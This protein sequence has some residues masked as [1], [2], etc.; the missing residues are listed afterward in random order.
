MADVID[1]KKYGFKEIDSEEK[2]K[3][4]PPV[5]MPRYPKPARRLHLVTQTFGQSIEEAYFWLVSSIRDDWGL[6]KAIKI[7]DIFTA[8]E[9][10]SFWGAAQQRLQLQQSQ[11]QQ[12]LGL[13]GKLLKDLFQLVREIRI[14]QER[15][16]LYT[17]SNKQIYKDA[18]QKIIRPIGSRRK[19]VPEE[20]VLKGYW[21]DMKDGGVKAPGSVYGLASTL[22]Y[23]TLPD[24]FF[25]APS[26]RKEEVARY[27]DVGLKDFNPRVRDV[28][29]KKLA[30]YLYW[31]EYTFGELSTRRKF[32][33]KYLRQHYESIQLYISWV[34]PYLKN[35]KRLQQN[36]EKSTSE[37]LIGAFEG[38]FVEIETLFYRD[39]PGCSK[40]P[41]CLLTMEFRTQ[42]HM[43]FHQ[44]GYQHKGPVHVGR[45]EFWMRGYCWTEKQIEKY[46]EL[47]EKETYDL[48]G[49]V[50]E[51]L[52][53]ALESLGKDIRDYL[54]GQDEEFPEDVTKKKEDEEEA[55]EKKKAMT[56]VID[57]FKSIFVGFK[58]IF[59][60]FVPEKE[61]FKG[62]EVPQWKQD[63][64][65][66]TALKDLEK[67]MYPSY[68]NFKKAH[69]M[70]TW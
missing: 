4:A 24:L 53:D 37:D 3:Y 70:I 18:N 5:P 40:K 41:V 47:R 56:G 49:S 51:S 64:D 42:P 60:T 19:S 7:T 15:L 32:T 23:S 2:T 65:F 66:K 30:A 38:S 39:I 33:I 58:D 45:T 36:F 52:K 26:M 6:G 59:R 48:L 67:R 69:R 20:T 34:K 54:K 29:K 11:V 31:K 14:V 16:D 63:A 68:K 13:I 35:V 62:E 10:S 61:K 27:V 57:P 8:S 55:E 1:I 50:D 22:G 12:Y 25:A 9:Q 28:L 17:A 21:V 44:D 43:D 46:K